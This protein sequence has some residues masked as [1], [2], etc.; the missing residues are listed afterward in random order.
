MEATTI[1]IATAAGGFCVGALAVIGLLRL[2]RNVENHTR[3]RLN[4]LEARIKDLETERRRDL[5][6]L[7]KNHERETRVRKNLIAIIKGLAVSALRIDRRL[8]ALER[9]TP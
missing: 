7:D 6:T 1:I 8:K 2:I 3:V 4:A 5:E 9:R